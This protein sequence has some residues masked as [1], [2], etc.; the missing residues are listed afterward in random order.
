MLDVTFSCGETMYISKKKRKEGRSLRKS[1]QAVG[2][3]SKANGDTNIKPKETE[4]ELKEVV[5]WGC[6]LLG[7]NAQ[8]HS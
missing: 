6:A 8:S 7:V 5:C 4:G 1:K 3:V 2:H